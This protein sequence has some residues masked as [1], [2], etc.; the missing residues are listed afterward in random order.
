MIKFSIQ[1][2][3]NYNV[4]LG[5]AKKRWNPKSS[6]YIYGIRNGL[7]IFNLELTTYMLK[8]ALFFICEVIKSRGVF[9]L[10]N[11]Q[12]GSY[13]Y[14]LGLLTKFGQY[15]INSKYIGGLLTNFKNVK[16]KYRSLA[17]LYRIPN[18]IFVNNL[19][20]CMS[21]VK[22]TKR[23]NIPLIGI[24]DS[25]SSPEYFTY[26]I[27]GNAESLISNKFYYSLV[28]KAIHLG[29]LQQREKYLKIKIKK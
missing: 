8:R 25:N 17:G 4:H 20:T 14:L 13:S 15:F 21:L 2:L 16:V 28:F 19:S 11:L 23:L 10:V 18:A 27:P 29:F 1:Q 3:F 12:F 6:V 7:S 22:E 26:P 9:L 5:F 24:A